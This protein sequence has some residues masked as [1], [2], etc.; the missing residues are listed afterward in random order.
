MKVH[1]IISESRLDEGATAEIF[2]KIWASATKLFD[3]NLLA[4]AAKKAGNG[5]AEKYMRTEII[6]KYKTGGFLG[7]GE[8]LDKAQWAQMDQAAKKYAEERFDAQFHRFEAPRP[9]E[10]IVKPKVAGTAGTGAQQVGTGIMGAD[11]KEIMKT[12]PG[13][14]G[15]AAVEND[16]FTKYPSSKQDVLDLAEAKFLD[17]CEDLY[18]TTDP[19]KLAQV[20]RSAGGSA[21]FANRFARRYGTSIG[22]KESLGVL[23]KTWLTANFITTFA[24][25]YK[26]LSTY[27]NNME[28]ARKYLE[29][30]DKGF[31]QLKNA[32]Q[33]EGMTIDGQ[34]PQN[35]EEWF[36]LYNHAQLQVCVAKLAEALTVTF[37]VSGAG[38][39]VFRGMGAFIP[40]VKKLT[41][42]AAPAAFN[43]F[44]NAMMQDPE[45]G[46]V[47][48]GIVMNTWLGKAT[49]IADI[50]Q[51]YQIPSEGEARARYTAVVEKINKG[52]ES[53]G[54]DNKEA[55]PTTPIG[56]GG[57]AD[58]ANG[59]TAQEPAAQSTPAAGPAAVDKSTWKRDWQGYPINPATGIAELD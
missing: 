33:L 19:K 45:P 34:S 11:G 23:Q 2:D 18:K 30:G 52:I 21:V 56:Q 26:P 43:L 10:T 24:I 38:Y 16:L 53:G 35:V 51:E 58:T 17:R 36:V 41:N 15:T 14:K 46:K 47:M 4:A 55:E 8:K 3:K 7:F 32:G 44:L 57:K 54:E 12:V 25:L 42:L 37:V 27:F 50:W 48:L 39:I 29:L 22:I 20:A 40:G 9:I 59:A 1:E 28:A 49:W 31:Q 5:G 6:S 13:T